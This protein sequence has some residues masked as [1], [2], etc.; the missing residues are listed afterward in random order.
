MTLSE[1]I[2]PVY[3]PPGKTS[4]SLITAL[5]KK[6]GI[7]KIGHAGTLDPFA[8]GVMILL[9]GK[10]YTKQSS[11][12]IEK[13]KEYEALIHLGVSTTTFDPEGEITS[14]SDII[15]SLSAI[16]TELAHFQ[17]EI[18][19]MPPMYSAKKVGGKK[20]YELARK[21]IE[22][23]RA[24]ITV[25]LTTTLLAYEYPSL[26]LKITCSKGTYIRTIANDIGKR[27]GCGAHLKKLTR[28]RCGPYVLK[29]CLNGHD[30]YESSLYFA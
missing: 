21:G 25:T 4:F 22:I 10:K 27:L 1:G 13:D 18:Q 17:G 14:E 29:D 20:L 7:K 2:I 26:R 12:F 28:T 8:E 24:P 15:P 11:F 23:P 16:E 6:T 30:L 9:V 19:Q 5:R 3:K